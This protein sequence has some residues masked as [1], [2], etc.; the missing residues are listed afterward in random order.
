MHFACL[1]FLTETK[2]NLFH[3]TSVLVQFA[4]QQNTDFG[5][6]CHL[7]IQ[8]RMFH[9]KT[10]DGSGGNIVLNNLSNLYF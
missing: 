5:G 10:C 4:K 1:F 8:S 9:T 2:R 3:L 6:K 7:K